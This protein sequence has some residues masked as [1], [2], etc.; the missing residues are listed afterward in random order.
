MSDVDPEELL[1]P[2]A[3]YG[4]PV[5]C[6]AVLQL[7]FE[8]DE[9]L[10]LLELELELEEADE[11]V[12]LEVGVEEVPDEEA[13]VVLLLAPT[14]AAKLVP[15]LLSLPPPHPASTAVPA[16]EASHASARRRFRNCCSMSGRSSAREWPCSCRVSC[17]RA[18]GR[19]LENRELS[20][21]MVGG[22][23]AEVEEAPAS[24]AHVAGKFPHI[25]L[26]YVAGCRP[27]AGVN[28]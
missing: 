25:A 22:T 11:A 5:S 24:A 18:A 23:K 20:R 7:E 2:S 3:G 8:L 16:D 12:L 27:T 17:E 19:S 26:Y 9:L 6:A 13:A 14:S 4:P 28:M 1:V 10:E 21:D 15:E